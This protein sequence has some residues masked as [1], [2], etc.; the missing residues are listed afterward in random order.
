MQR[1][2]NYVSQQI[3]SLI[4]KDPDHGFNYNICTYVVP[5]SMKPKHYLIALDPKT[6]TYN[7]FV[8]TGEAVLQILSQKNKSKIRSFG[9]RSGFDHNKIP[10]ETLAWNT[11]PL[12]KDIVSALLVEIVKPLPAVGGDHELFVVAIKKYK[13]F[14]TDDTCLTTDDIY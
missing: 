9:K 6:K 7:N 3:Y 2:W 10:R 14:N 4:T 11:Y 13:Y 8:Q 12:A 5:I 1:P